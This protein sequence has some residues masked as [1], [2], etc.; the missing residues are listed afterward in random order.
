MLI[1]PRIARGSIQG[2]VTLV[3]DD[4][5]IEIKAESIDMNVTFAAKS[6]MNLKLNIPPNASLFKP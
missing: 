4:F 2:A 5:Q 6:T 3:A 1:R